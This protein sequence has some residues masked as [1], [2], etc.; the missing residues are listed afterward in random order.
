MRSGRSGP[1]WI[2]R[3]PVATQPFDLMEG[4]PHSGQIP[5]HSR[6]LDMVQG[7]LVGVGVVSC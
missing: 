6:T 5:T 1:T 2:S 4:S 7:R 3:W